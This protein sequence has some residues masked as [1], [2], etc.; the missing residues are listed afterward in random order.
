M[1]EIL[2]IDFDKLQEDILSL[3]SEKKYSAIRNIFLEMNPADIAEIMN[4]LPLANLPL[5]YRLLP[6]ELAADTF[7]EMDSDVQSHLIGSFS[8][9]ELRAVLDE[10]LF[11]EVLGIDDSDRC[12]NTHI[13]IDQRSL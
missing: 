11:G 12:R 10:I 1:D 3:L 9:T 7:V 8:D 13:F 4:E 2:N 5:L 6:K